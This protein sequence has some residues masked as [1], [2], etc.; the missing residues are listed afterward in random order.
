ML[1]DLEKDRKNKNYNFYNQ[2]VADEYT[3]EAN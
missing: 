3:K 2:H 1:L